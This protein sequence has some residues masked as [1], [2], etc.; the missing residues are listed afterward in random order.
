MISGPLQNSAPTDT[1]ST[2]GPSAGGSNHIPAC[3]MTSAIPKPN[4]TVSR[5]YVPHPGRRVTLALT[6]RQPQRR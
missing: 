1:N 5:A 2:L 3:F 4:R 6:Q